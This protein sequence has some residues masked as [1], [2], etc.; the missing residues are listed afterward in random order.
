MLQGHCLIWPSLSR[1]LCLPSA[2]SPIAVGWDAERASP[3]KAFVTN[4][5][6]TMLVQNL[7]RKMQNASTH[8]A[9]MVR[10]ILREAW[11]V[12]SIY[13][14]VYPS[15]CQSMHLWIDR[16]NCLSICLFMLLSIYLSIDLSIYLSIYFCISSSVSPCW[17]NNVT[18]RMQ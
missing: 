18:Y 16:S 9:V 10:Q 4:T 1:L 5:R 3:R 2:S 8:K 13:L 11:V 7:P 14:S 12:L 17:K 15:I 6:R